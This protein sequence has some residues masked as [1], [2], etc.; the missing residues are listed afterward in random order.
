MPI[1]DSSLV[2]NLQR[3]H[4]DANALDVFFWTQTMHLSDNAN[5]IYFE[6]K[7]WL[8]TNR[9]TPPPN[10]VEWVACYGLA[11][12]RLQDWKLPVDLSPKEMTQWREAGYYVELKDFQ[13]AFADVAAGFLYLAGQD[14]QLAVDII[15]E[16]L[17]QKLAELDRLTSLPLDTYMPRYLEWQVRKRAKATGLSPADI[18]EVVETCDQEEEHMFEMRDVKALFDLRQQLQSFEWGL[19]NYR[20]IVF[21]HNP[22]IGLPNVDLF[23]AL[24][25]IDANGLL[26]RLGQIDK[27]LRPIWQGLAD[28][29]CYDLNSDLEPKKFWWRHWPKKSAGKAGA[30]RK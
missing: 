23:K 15:Q 14:Q 29:G 25:Q 10:L 22:E 24:M 5:E 4:P 17:A 28:L 2:R 7:D 11:R 9:Q 3:T 13:E 19:E 8:D 12:F 27:K 16:Q 1:R 18:E 21:E 20:M 26:W 6:Y 30:P